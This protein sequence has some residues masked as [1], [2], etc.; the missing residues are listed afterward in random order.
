MIAALLTSGIALIASAQ[1]QPQAQ[2]SCTDPRNRNCQGARADRR[3]G[4][5]E[6]VLSGDVDRPISRHVSLAL[7][8]PV[9][10]AEHHGARCLAD[11]DAVS[12][13]CA[14]RRT[15]CSTSIR[16]SPA[17]EASAASTAWRT[18]RTAN[19]RASPR[20]R[21]SRTWRGCT[22]LTTLRSAVRRNRSKAKRISLAAGAR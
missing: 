1:E 21:Q 10:P 16:K 11:H 4:A 9:Q 3:T 5:L 2:Q 22:S 20:P 15:L 8:G 14:W 17:E 12:S 13:A 19:C 18:P 6:S 7:R